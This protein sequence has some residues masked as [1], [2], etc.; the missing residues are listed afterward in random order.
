MNDMKYFSSKRKG[1][2]LGQLSN[3]LK[4]YAT[5]HLCPD[6]VGSLKLDA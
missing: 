3:S 2:S 5:K 6:L 1:I 4:Q